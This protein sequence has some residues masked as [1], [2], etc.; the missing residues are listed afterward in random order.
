MKNFYN[1][2]ESTKYAMTEY[3]KYLEA[4][5][6]TVLD[7]IKPICEAFGIT[8]YDYIVKTSGQRETLVVE[9]TK[10][11][12]SDDSIGAIV[13]ELVNYIWIQCGCINRLSQYRK[14]IKNTLTGYWLKGE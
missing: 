3:E 6:Q 2:G 14:Y 11:G 10:I 12:C 8:N 1:I 13:Q 9:N 4:K 7:T 5:R